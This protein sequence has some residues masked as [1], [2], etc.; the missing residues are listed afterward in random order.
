M[1]RMSITLLN[2]TKSLWD[3]SEKRVSRK[4]YNIS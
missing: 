1:N 3:D 4:K 2:I